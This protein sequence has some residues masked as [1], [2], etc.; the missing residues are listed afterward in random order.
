MAY[1]VNHVVFKY[2]CCCVPP[3]CR[4]LKNW[5]SDYNSGL[6]SDTGLCGILFFGRTPTLTLGFQNI[7]TPTPT[8][9]L[10]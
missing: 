2:H 5:D 3:G 10:G 9:A 1:L 6:K 4:V 8:L 7:R